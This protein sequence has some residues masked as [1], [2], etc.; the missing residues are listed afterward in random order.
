VPATGKS[1]RVALFTPTS[2]DCAD[3]MTAIRS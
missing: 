3:K 2:V 1:L